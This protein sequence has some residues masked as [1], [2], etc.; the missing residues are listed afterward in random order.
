MFGFLAWLVY[1]RR[2]S[3][4]KEE[5]GKEGKESVEEEE[6]EGVRV[7]KVGVADELG[8]KGRGEEEGVKPG[9]SNDKSEMQEV[10]TNKR[11]A[12][13]STSF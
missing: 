5:D 9:S 12:L 3:G 8:R 13:T 11:V 2:D 1:P 7:E 10:G 6:G 4:E